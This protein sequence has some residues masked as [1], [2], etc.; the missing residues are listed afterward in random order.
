MTTITMREFSRNLSAISKRVSKGESFC[1]SKNSEIIFEVK[2]N[3]KKTNKQT[4][5]DKFKKHIV[6]N[7]KG[8]KNISSEIDNI[9]YK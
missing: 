7:T 5:H 8:L 9:I 2:P 6:K 4:L 1:V 3:I